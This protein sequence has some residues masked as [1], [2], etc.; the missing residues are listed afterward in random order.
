[1]KP[2]KN[3]LLKRLQKIKRLNQLKEDLKEL[4]VKVK[5]EKST[6]K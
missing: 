4:L 6:F 3:D 5:M 2:T 1:M